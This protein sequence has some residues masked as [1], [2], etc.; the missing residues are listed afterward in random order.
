MNINL[1]INDHNIIT[2]A[3]CVSQ[4]TTLQIVGSHMNSNA[5]PGTKLFATENWH[6]KAEKI[7]TVVVV[8]SRCLLS[9]EGI[10]SNNLFLLAFA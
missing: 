8:Y 10:G 5:E 7:L 4:H 1:T 6:M 2:V 9:Q 3:E